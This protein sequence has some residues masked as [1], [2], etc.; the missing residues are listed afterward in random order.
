MTR[1]MKKYPML[2]D[3]PEKTLIQKDIH[4]P[5]FMATLFTIAMEAMEAKVSGQRWCGV[6][7]YN[8]ILLSHEKEWNNTIC[9]NMDEP[10]DYHIKWSKSDK[11]KYHIIYIVESKKLYK[12]AYLLYKTE[13][14]SQRGKGGRDKLGTWY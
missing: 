6:Y 13:I 14:D 7:I 9:S 3:F 10:R 12:W 11:D 5:V 2:L 4:S 1:R 8:A